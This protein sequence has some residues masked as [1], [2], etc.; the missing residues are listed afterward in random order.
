MALKWYNISGSYEMTSTVQVLY[1]TTREGAWLGLDGSLLP[2]H[3]EAPKRHLTIVEAERPSAF[4]SGFRLNA[5][6]Q[7]FMVDFPSIHSIE[8]GPKTWGAVNPFLVRRMAEIPDSFRVVQTVCSQSFGGSSPCMVR[9]KACEKGTVEIWRN[10]VLPQMMCGDPDYSVSMLGRGIK[11]VNHIDYVGEGGPVHIL[12]EDLT[13]Y[14]ISHLDQVKQII[15][16]IRDDK[17]RVDVE[18]I[19]AWFVGDDKDHKVC[20]VT[21]RL[22]DRLTML[23]IS[24]D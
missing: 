6:I 24:K 20:A 17:V 3:R 15:R 9:R 1:T 10:W 12:G 2:T 7:R 5:I 11:K 19:F 21:W 13:C 18:S 14:K 22:G 16:S 4:C 23:A 8:L